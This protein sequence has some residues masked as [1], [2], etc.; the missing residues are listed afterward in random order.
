[1]QQCK[2]LASILLMLSGIDFALAA[3][4]FVQER[5]VRVSV[6]DAANDGT[7]LPLRRD[8]SDKWPANAADRTNAPPIP[9]SGYW[10]EQVPRQH[11]PSNP[12]ELP[13]DLDA[14]YP[15]SPSYPPGFE[16]THLPTIQ[17]PTDEPNPLNPL[18][19][20]GNTYSSPSFYNG[21]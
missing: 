9:R 13:I 17:A 5:G 21:Q 1:M 16:P 3:P 8:Q 7:A 14:N 11:K 6:V 20:H 12:A 2:I 10:R 15:P 18:S 4:V 19:P